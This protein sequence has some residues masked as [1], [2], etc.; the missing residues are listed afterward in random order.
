MTYAT[1]GSRR[2][3]LHDQKILDEVVKMVE[4]FESSGVARANGLEILEQRCGRFV[5]GKHVGELRGWASWT[6][7]RSGGWLKSGPG[8]RNGGVV[9]PG[10]VVALEVTDFSGKQ[11]VAYGRAV[12]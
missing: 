8:Y 5:Q 6:F 7:V 1:L 4:H 3:P 10:D 12:K 9:R 2:G 11:F